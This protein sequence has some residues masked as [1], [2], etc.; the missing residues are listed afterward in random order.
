VSAIEPTAADL[1]AN[2]ARTQLA[3]ESAWSPHLEAHRVAR[4]YGLTVEQLMSRRRMRPLPDARHQLWRLLR[5]RGWSFPRIARFANVD[6]STVI[7]GLRSE[8]RARKRAKY[9]S[10]RALGR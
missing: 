9:L 4:A 5:A 8:T 2:L 1:E 10:R 3:S 7:Y 6:H